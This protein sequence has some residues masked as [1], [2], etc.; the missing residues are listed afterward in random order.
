MK[1]NLRLPLADSC[2][3]FESILDCEVMHLGIKLIDFPGYQR[4][5]LSPTFPLR[6]YYMYTCTSAIYWKASKNFPPFFVRQISLIKAAC[7][8]Y[9]FS[10]SRIFLANSGLS[11]NFCN[12]N[13]SRVQ[14]FPYF[15]LCSR[16]LFLGVLMN[17]Q[18]LC[19]LLVQWL[20]NF[21]REN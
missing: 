8:N 10:L 1:I 20:L 4:I 21:P 12:A 5:Q 14:F 15:S 16:H 17:R 13:C 3:T 18:W 11:I 19:L 6:H 9:W 2:A 7:P